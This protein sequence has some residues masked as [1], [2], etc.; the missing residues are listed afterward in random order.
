M[1]LRP[2]LWL[3]RRLPGPGYSGDAEYLTV[4]GIL[5][6]IAFLEGL[7]GLWVLADVDQVMRGEGADDMVGI[8][9]PVGFLVAPRV[10]GGRWSRALFGPAPRCS[11]IKCART[12][13]AQ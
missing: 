12:D 6:E 1:P 7:P 5:G 10:T 13:A 4:A 8:L 3:S 11:L 2:G 9:G